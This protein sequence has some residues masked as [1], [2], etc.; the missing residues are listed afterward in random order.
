M[1]GCP[2]CGGKAVEV[3]CYE[4]WVRCGWLCINL[5]CMNYDLAGNRER[6]VDGR[7]KN[8]DTMVFPNQR[9]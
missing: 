5:E 2:E 3:L 1:K 6:I 8:K 4:T 9:L 7:P